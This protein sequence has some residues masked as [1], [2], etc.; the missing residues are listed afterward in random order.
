MTKMKIRAKET[1]GELEDNGDTSET[2]EAL[3]RQ[4]R[5]DWRQWKHSETMEMRQE[6]IY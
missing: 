3:Q 4:W 1:V 5:C 2:M 6:A